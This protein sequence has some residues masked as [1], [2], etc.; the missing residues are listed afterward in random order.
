MTGPGITLFSLAQASVSLAQLKM[1]TGCESRFRSR[2]RSSSIGLDVGLVIDP[3]TRSRLDL[4][5]EI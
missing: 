5:L 4:V 3:I 1:K 2:Y